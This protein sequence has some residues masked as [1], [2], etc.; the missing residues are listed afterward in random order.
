MLLEN[1]DI[2]VPAESGPE[3]VR[4]SPGDDGHAEWLA[5]FQR[6][7]QQQRERRRQQQR[8]PAPATREPR[9]RSGG[10]TAA[11]IGIGVILGVIL[12]VVLLAIAALIVVNQ[13][14]DLNIPEIPGLNGDD[15]GGG[16]NGGG[17]QNIPAQVIRLR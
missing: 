6:E 10:R 9:R 5:H 14:S 7:Q 1:G 15:S 11:G 16:G 13:V 12:V 2:L 17:G 4:L 3:M 8:R